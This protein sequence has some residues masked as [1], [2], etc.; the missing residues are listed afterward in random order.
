MEAPFTTE[1]FFEVLIQY[2]EAVWPVQILMNLLALAAVALLVWPRPYS[3]R[4]ISGIL[5]LLWAWTGIAH[6]LAFFATVNNAAYGFGAVFLAGAAAF[7]W[8]GTMKGN[9]VFGSASG[10][11]RVLGGVLVVYA[12]LVYPVLSE[13]LGHGYPAT[14]TFGL[15]CPTTIFTTG[16]LC[17]LGAPFP[18]YVLVAP[19]L[20]SVVGVQ[21][22]FLFG[23]YQDLGLLV[24]GLVGVLL[25]FRAGEAGKGRTL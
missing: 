12:L 6:H 11:Y 10:P 20:W 18:R 7:L 25:G 13:V 1:Q 9:L 21:A 16:M 5:A 19:V 22:A 17:F 3:S 24:S 8:A 15:P 14:P 4:L 2:N 23:V